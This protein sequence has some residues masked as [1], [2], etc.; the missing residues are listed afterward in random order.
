MQTDGHPVGFIYIQI[1]KNDIHLSFDTRDVNHTVLR[2]I[3][4]RLTALVT[5]RY[6]PE[7]IIFDHPDGILRSVLATNLYFAK[8]KK[9]IRIIEPWRYKVKDTAFDEEGYIINQSMLSALPFGYFDTKR[10]GCGWIAAYNLLKMYG[11]EC[12][13]QETAE[14][15]NKKTWL[16]GTLG[17]NALHLY[18]YLKK[19]GLPVRFHMG[20]VKDITQIMEQSSMGIVLYFHQ[21]GA[22]FSA[23]GKEEGCLMHF[24]NSRYGKRNDC[25]SPAAFFKER[26]YLPFAFV[27]VIR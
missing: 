6:H 2:M 4:L 14:G 19:K 26:A 12:F 16:Q 9:M 7:H 22:H 21:T 27:I 10:K 15:L 17:V 8:G 13:M 5:A 24:Y 20:S 18:R 1:E 23:Y 3:I 11:F 25:L